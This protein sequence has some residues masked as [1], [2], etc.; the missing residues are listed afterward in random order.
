[1]SLSTA[2]AA[3]RIFALADLLDRATI[4]AREIERLTASEPNLD[5][6][7]AYSIQSA[8]LNLRLA[9]GEKRIGWKMGLTSQAKRDQMGLKSSIYGYLTDA[10]QIFSPG[11]FSL[12]GHIHPKIEP[13]LIFK[14]K[15]EL[16]GQVTRAEALAACAGV[17]PALEILDSRFKGFKYFSLPDVVA[18]NASSS[19]LVFDPRGFVDPSSLD[20][21]NLDLK[22]FASGILAQEARSSEISGDPV[23]SLVQ[24]VA[25]LHERGE[26]LESGSLVLAGAATTAI[27]LEKGLKVTLEVTGLNSISLDVL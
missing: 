14:M 16:S 12:E 15:H 23:E 11:K 6:A 4:E 9:R 5:L 3:H 7:S 17:A 8:G 1:M 27:A 21:E 18:D 26:T 2:L 19:M 13:E 20:L 24:L 22:M 25:L 10:M